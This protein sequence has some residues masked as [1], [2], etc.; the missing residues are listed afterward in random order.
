MIVESNFLLGRV[1]GGGVTLLTVKFVVLGT[2]SLLQF[3]RKEA[4][5]T[6]TN[7][8]LK[9]LVFPVYSQNGY[10]SSNYMFCKNLIRCSIIV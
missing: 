3:R 8:D 9:I 6:P 2:T 1:V 7:L 10:L 4:L 5:C